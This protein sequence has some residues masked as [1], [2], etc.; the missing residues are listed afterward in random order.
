MTLALGT[1]LLADGTNG[2]RETAALHVQIYDYAELEPAALGRFV[3][4]TQ[5]ILASTGMSV[6]VSLCRGIGAL[7]CN[8]ATRAAAPLVVR[9]VAGDAKIMKNVR[10]E[11]LGQAYADHNGGTTASVFLAP[12][13]EQAAAANIPWIVVLSYA[14]VHEVGHLLLGDRAHTA[15]GVMKAGWDRSD[16][17]A[18]SQNRCHFTNEQALILASRYK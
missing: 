10:R 5:D 15:R 1:N 14:A 4:L 16:Y 18:M 13:R 9:I 12:V 7:P 17:M 6:Q 8:G 2:S 3:S 11:P